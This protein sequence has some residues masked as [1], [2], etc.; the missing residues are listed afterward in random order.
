MALTNNYRRPVI[1]YEADVAALGRREVEAFFRAHYGPSN[2]VIAVVGDTTPDKAC[3]HPACSWCLHFPRAS[4]WSPDV[5]TMRERGDVP[6]GNAVWGCVAAGPQAQPFAHSAVSPQQG[7][8][9]RFPALSSVPRLGRCAALRKSTLAGGGSGSPRSPRRARRR[10][11]RGHR[12]GLC[13]WSARPAQ[14][15]PS[16]RRTTGPGSLPQTRPSWTS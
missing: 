10:R 11:C 13:S 3:S 9:V 4:T 14:A 12:A 8:A 15:Q 2:L 5:T 1:G 7:C 6:Q 16:C